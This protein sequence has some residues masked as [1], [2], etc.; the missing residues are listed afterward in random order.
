MALSVVNN[1]IMALLGLSLPAQGMPGFRP[2][3]APFFPVVNFDD[4]SQLR[5]YFRE[6]YSAA[7][8]LDAP[9]V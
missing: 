6:R 8:S 3:I 9:L 7:T 4:N 2:S 1:S 5:T